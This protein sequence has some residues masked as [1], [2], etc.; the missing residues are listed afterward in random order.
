MEVGRAG[1]GGWLRQGVGGGRWEVGCVLRD[2]TRGV[3][4]CIVREVPRKT[5]FYEY[6]V[7]LEGEFYVYCFII[8]KIT[9]YIR[10][11]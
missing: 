4:S 7:G 3:T 9:Y 6:F 8:G 1:D 10:F 2:N 5:A 11:F